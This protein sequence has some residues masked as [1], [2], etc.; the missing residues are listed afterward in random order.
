[1]PE[2]SITASGSMA[3]TRP[4]GTKIRRRATDLD[5]DAQCPRRGGAHAQG[6]DDVADLADPVPVGV[7][8]GQ[9]GQPGDI[10]LVA[11]VT[12]P[13][14]WRLSVPCRLSCSVPA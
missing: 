8:D 4:I 12:E 14:R 13:P 1:M 11:V 3:V 7:E 6:D 9:P 10:A 2:L 5:D